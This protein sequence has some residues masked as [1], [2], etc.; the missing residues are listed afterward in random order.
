[1][2]GAL[3]TII[4]PLAMIIVYT[5]I[6]SQVMQARLPGIDGA[7]VYSVFLMAGLLPWGLLVDL[8][9]R[10]PNLF[11]DQSNLLKKVQFPKGALLLIAISNALINFGI[12]F[13][14]FLCFL[15]LSG[16]FPGLV[17]LA[18]IPLL[19]L[20]VFLA[21]GLM[22]ILGILNIFFRDVAPS[23]SIVLQFGFWFTPILYSEKMIPVAYHVYL[24]L[25]PLSPL[26]KAYQDIFLDGI[27]PAWGSLLPL[28]LLSL[29]L[30]WLGLFL[31]SRRSEE[32]VDE[33]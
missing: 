27:W 8:I 4:N 25:N 16:Q 3:W 32:M 2:L 10:G 26:F 9:S 14:L 17:I 28:L 12:I 22:L 24:H 31:F 20:Q 19:V 33:L 15:I 18:V 13:T 29:F 1:M 7:F 23:T 30:N 6:F 11:L 5:V 21:A